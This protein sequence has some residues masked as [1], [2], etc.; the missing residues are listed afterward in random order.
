SGQALPS[1]ASARRDALL[2]AGE[3]K[4]AWIDFLAA[5]CAAHPVV[6]VLEDLHWA[7][8]STVK[9]IEAALEA[10]ADRP[11]LVLGFGRPEVHDLF[12]SLWARCDV[13]T[14]RLSPLPRWA[15]ERIAREIL[16]AGATDEVVARVVERSSGN[17]FFLE[18]LCRAV[19]EHH[20][21]PCD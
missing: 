21:D 19:V 7:D 1:L 8:L 5:E 10:L 3:V 15:S 17:A 12:P 9:L 13:Q 11:L 2:F 18:E 16:G 6:L 4:R 14:L 20:D